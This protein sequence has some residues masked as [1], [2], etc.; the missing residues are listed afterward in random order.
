MLPPEYL[1][2]LQMDNNNGDDQHFQDDINEAII[3]SMFEQEQNA[4]EEKLLREVMKI[5]ALEH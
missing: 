1:R 4:E 5:S 3:Q 2:L